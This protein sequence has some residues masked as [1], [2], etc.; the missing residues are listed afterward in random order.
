MSKNKKIINTSRLEDFS[1]DDW[2]SQIAVG[3][4]GAFLCCKIFGSKMAQD[5]KGGVILNIA[6]DLSVIAPNQ[7]LYNHLNIIKKKQLRNRYWK[8]RGKN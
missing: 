8:K 4:T 7:D 1:L 6:S 3:L 2:N 5:G